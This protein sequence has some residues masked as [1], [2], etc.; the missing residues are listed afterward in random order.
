MTFWIRIRETNTGTERPTFFPT[1][2]NIFRSTSLAQSKCKEAAFVYLN[3]GLL[4]VE[5]GGSL[6]QQ[7]LNPARHCSHH[8]HCRLQVAA[9]QLPGSYRYTAT[10]IQRTD[11][12]KYGT[13]IM[14]VKT[15][16]FLNK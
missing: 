6:L 5:P 4:L 15:Q 14:T 2:V 3:V 11:I 1:K 9:I 16:Y 7:E 8:R 10:V 13:I 12:T